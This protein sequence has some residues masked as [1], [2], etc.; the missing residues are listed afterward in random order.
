MR[1]AFKAFCSGY[2]C[3]ILAP[4]TILAEQHYQS[5]LKRVAKRE[6][7][8]NLA[9]LSRFQTAAEQKQ[10]IKDLSFGLVDIVIGTH[11]LLSDDVKF[12]NLG[13]IVIDE[14]QKFGVKQKKN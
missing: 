10:I 14:E 4:I 9:L 12:K 1:S 11:R 5:F 7:G 13:L 2:Q 6:Y 3:A 8:V